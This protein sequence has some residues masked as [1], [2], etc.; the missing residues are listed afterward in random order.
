[1]SNTKQENKIY[2]AS[3]DPGKNNFAFSIE[4]IYID[5]CRD[6]KNLSQLPFVGKTIIIENIN[7]SG[8]LDKTKYVDVNLFVNLTVVL[9]KY[10]K[11]W[12][13]CKFILIERQMSFGSNKNNTLALKIA[14]HCLSYFTFMYG[15]FKNLIE[16]PAYHKTQILDA[17]S[18]MLKPARKKWAVQKAIEILSARDYNKDI[19]KKLNDVKKKDDMSDCILM[20]LSFIYQV[21]VLKKKF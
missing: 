2:I 9:D 11:Y 6:L 12:D 20:N 19:L 17:P 3:I 14:Q 18:K 4:E 21:Y 8:G 7:L 1:M 13:M 10:K 16:Y 5:K 15:K